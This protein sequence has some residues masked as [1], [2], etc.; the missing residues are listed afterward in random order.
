MGKTAPPAA[1]RHQTPIT[2]VTA[3]QAIAVLIAVTADIVGTVHRMLVPPRANTETE[4]IVHPVQMLPPTPITQATAAQATAALTAGTADI[5]GTGLLMWHYLTAIT[6]AV[7]TAQPVPMP[8]VI[9]TIQVTAAPATAVLT[10]VT[11]VIVI[12]AA[13]TPIL[14][15]DIIE[16]AKTA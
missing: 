7:K 14:L 12:V 5:V 16:A 3:A 1:M 9:L 6:E 13:A 2:Q 11:M 4:K 10:A 15:R 8:P